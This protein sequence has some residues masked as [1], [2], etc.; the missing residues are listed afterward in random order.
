MH[1][2][3]NLEILQKMCRKTGTSYFHI[4]VPKDSD[5]EEEE[6]EECSQ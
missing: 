6:E 2:N 1:M 3:I 5:E 4:D